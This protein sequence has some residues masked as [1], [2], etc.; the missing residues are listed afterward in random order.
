[1]T[2]S[3]ALIN[4]WDKNNT[5]INK[6]ITLYFLEQLFMEIICFHWSSCSSTSTITAI[7][8]SIKYEFPILFAE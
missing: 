4:W 7:T 8:T 3:T 5:N 2:T 1:M 6:L